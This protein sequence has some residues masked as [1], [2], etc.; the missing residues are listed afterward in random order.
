MISNGA[1]PSKNNLSFKYDQIFGNIDFKGKNVLEIGG[2]HGVFCFYASIRGA[3][4]VIN[5]EP[6]CAGCKSGY[7]EKFKLLK[8]ALGVNNV[9]IVEKTFQDYNPLN[10]KFDIILLYNSINHLDEEACIDLRTNSDSWDSYKDIFKKIYLL[11]NNDAMIIMGDC[12]NKNFFP[13]IGLKNPIYKKIEWFK[14][15]S[16]NV[17]IELLKECGFGDPSISWTT[18]NS[19]GKLGK[20]LFGNKYISFFLVSHFVLRMTK[21]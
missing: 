19:L 5:L 13:L 4:W 20:V 18:F 2:G 1:Y 3:K 12:S 10:R 6:E 8:D 9:E 15:Q 17:W 11:S 21:K 14:H 16:P 7:I